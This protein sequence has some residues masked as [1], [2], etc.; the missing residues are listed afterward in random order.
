MTRVTIVTNEGDQYVSVLA[1]ELHEDDGY[2]RA[3]SA[4]Y[5]LVAVVDMQYVKWAHLTEEKGR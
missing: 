4:K 2:L 1:D 5:G 3:Y